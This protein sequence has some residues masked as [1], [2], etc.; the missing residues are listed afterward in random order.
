[1]SCKALEHARAPLPRPAFIA[2]PIPPLLHTSI[3]LVQKDLRRSWILHDLSLACRLGRAR[4]WLAHNALLAAMTWQL[5]ALGLHG[6]RPLPNAGSVV[7]ALRRGAAALVH[8]RLHGDKAKR[9]LALLC[10]G[11]VVHAVPNV[12]VS[13]ERRLIGTEG[14]THHTDRE[15]S[16]DVRQVAV[17]QLFKLGCWPVG[18]VGSRAVVEDHLVLIILAPKLH[19][20]CMLRV[21]VHDHQLARVTQI[22]A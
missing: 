5:D 4:S 14:A 19:V 20:M 12:T 1:M 16:W 6:L 2:P 18:L 22:L 11:N 17:Q 8:L 10:P 3:H 21:L 7:V 15:L 13:I 9:L